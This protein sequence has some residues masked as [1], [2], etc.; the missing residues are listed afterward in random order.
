MFDDIDGLRATLAVAQLGSFSAAAR[1]L[2]LSTNAVSHRVAR[3]EARLGVRLFERTTR[4]VRP[5]D[6]ADRLLVRARRVIDELEAVENDVTSASLEGAVRVALPPDLAGPAFFREVGALLDTS[7]RLRLELFGRSTPVD[8]RK[9]ALDLVVWGGPRA[10]IPPELVARSLGSIAWSL[11]A[12]ASYLA[13]HGLPTRPS[14]LTQHRCLVAR[15]PDPE[16]KWTLVDQHGV[17]VDVPISGNLESDH[18]RVLLEALRSG[19]GIGI[20]PER[21]VERGI[22][23]GDWVRVLPTFTFRPIEVALVS[24]KGRWKVP[25]VRLVAQVLET[26]LRQLTQPR[27]LQ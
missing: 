19:L 26:A 25:A 15:T 18:P 22:A 14:D 12:S 8:P 20:R 5:T 3:L 10:R 17:E 11:C 7:P 6:A 16:R 4:L 1:S 13:R 27:R 24:P 23:A 21:E 9:E 2:H